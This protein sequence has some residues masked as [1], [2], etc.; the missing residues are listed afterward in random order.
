MDLKKIKELS[1]KYYMN[2]FHRQ[3]ICFVRGNG[4]KLYDTTGKEYTD[5]VSGIGVNCLG[6]NNPDLTKAI[7]EQA[8]KL[9]HS[10]NLYY[11]EE[12]AAL[13]EKLLKDTIFTKM[14]LANSGAEAN[15]CAIKLVRKHYN[16]RGQ[17]RPVAEKPE[18]SLCYIAYRA[19]FSLY[20]RFHD[21]FFRRHYSVPRSGA[22][23][24]LL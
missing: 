14:F 4:N 1:N 17:H 21:N 19:Y 18:F 6:Y 8:A 5:F 2:V 23:F 11:N 10:S 9:I 15:E 22:C 13:C 3:N 24:S 7:S 20:K 12:Q 16:L